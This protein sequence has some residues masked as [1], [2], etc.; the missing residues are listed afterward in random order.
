MQPGDLEGLVGPG[1]SR[2]AGGNGSVVHRMRHVTQW[3]AVLNGDSELLAS[4]NM[5]TC[6]RSPG[7]IKSTGDKYNINVGDISQI[8]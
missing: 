1:D 7:G 3:K 4:M 6:L 2:C 8:K 5:P